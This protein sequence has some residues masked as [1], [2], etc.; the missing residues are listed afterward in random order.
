MDAV[1]F[2]VQ[3]FV[4]VN[5]PI[6]LKMKQAFISNIILLVLINFLIK[7]L[8]I[9]GV[10]AQ[11]Q[12]LV[13]IEQYGLY[14]DYFNFVLLFQFI[15]DPGL[16]NWNSQHVATNRDA[17]AIH[18]PLLIN[19]KLILGLV[20][21]IVIII[22]AY[23]TGHIEWWLLL[24]AGL[25][26]FLSTLFLLLR[27]CLSALGF[28]TTDS[29]VSALDK[30]LMILIIG[31]IVW[32]PLGIEMDLELFVVGQTCA[33]L[34]ACLVVG[35]IVF[36][37]VNVASWKFS[38]VGSVQMV[39][40]CLPYVWILVFMTFYSR[41]DGQLLSMMI[42]D[43]HYQ[44]G[45]YAA[46]YRFYDAANM[47]GYLFGA[48]LLPM[49]AFHKTNIIE[50]KNLVDIGF[51]FAIVSA[52]IICIAVLFYGAE[53]M[54][55]LLDSYNPSFLTTLFLLMGAYFCVAIG[56][57]FG[58]LL[59]SVGEIRALNYIFGSGLLMNILIN[60]WL[61]PSY[62]AAGAATAAICTQFLVLIL[63][64]FYVNKLL[65]ITVN[66][67]I[68]FKSLLFVGASIGVFL[69]LSEVNWFIKTPLII[70][71]VACTI[72]L[73]LAIAIRLINIKDIAGLMSKK[74]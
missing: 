16:Q 38:F 12:N 45:V 1:D 49:F 71:I 73:L 4:E 67:D 48:L 20:F 52:S 69:M 19:T 36:S 40:D 33:Y 3:R 70:C 9:F 63:Q 14:F 46:C 42:D 62:G 35:M 8:Y 51:R 37:K 61:I 50:L 30:L 13:G 53:F 18:F 66:S 39:K 10:E 28:F 5:Q 74:D 24:F 72:C 57:I 58:T 2:C 17:S 65:S 31:G 55:I 26:L 7:P 29:W 15:N 54:S 25:N 43:N 47:I 27:S 56:Y 21:G 23:L 41:L 6:N 34:L 44:T 11:V 60:V 59:M 68:I 64:I 22:F 32:L